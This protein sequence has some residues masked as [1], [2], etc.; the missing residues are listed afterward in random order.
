MEKSMKSTFRIVL[1]MVLI[2]CAAHRAH[3]QAKEVRV[4]A[5]AD[6][7]FAMKDLAVDFEKQSGIKI[8]VTY[9]SSGNFFSQ[10]QNGA[11]FDLFFSADIDFPRK[12]D[13]AG[14]AEPNTFYPYATGRIVLW[15]PPDTKVDVAR[16][17]WNALLDPSVQK[18]S[19]ANPQHAPYGRAAV[20]AMQKAGIYEQVKEKLVYA[21]NISQAAQFA[22]SGNA[23]AAIVA[24][25]LTLSPAMKDGKSWEIPADMHPP[26]EQAAIVMKDAKNKESAKAFLEY[27]KSEKGRE[28]LTRYGF[29]L[30]APEHK[31]SAATTP[32]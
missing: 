29:A 26:I 7:Q 3:S 8:D 27:V 24:L 19:V 20:A 31:K 22:Q 1:A 11:P 30:P 10:L 6:L 32:K 21:E 14:L 15:M 13:A 4:A 2:F 12:L 5:A 16:L 17:Q 18:I 25:S 28:A 9:G 23:Q